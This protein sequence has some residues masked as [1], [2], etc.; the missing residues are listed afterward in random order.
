VVCWAEGGGPLEKTR[1]VCPS[2]WEEAGGV[3]MGRM[4]YCWRL[5]ILVVRRKGGRGGGSFRFWDFF[6][7]RV[8]GD[9]GAVRAGWKPAG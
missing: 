6:F 2:R 1:R 7:S 3:F 8:G 9:V 4:F 5:T